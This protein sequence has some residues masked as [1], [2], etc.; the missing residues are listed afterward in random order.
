MQGC[1]N[2]YD[3]YNFYEWDPDHFEGYTTNDN[4][5][6]WKSGSKIG[7]VN[8]QVPSFTYCQGCGSPNER[9]L[10]GNSV[11]PGVARVVQADCINPDTA[12]P[13]R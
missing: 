2:K 8:Y 9:I 10:W 3:C 12:Q 6:Y 1:I 4:P 11:D 5:D 7:Y 13:R